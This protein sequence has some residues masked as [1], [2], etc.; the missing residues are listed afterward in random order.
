MHLS[1]FF[2]F[3]SDDGMKTLIKSSKP[4]IFMNQVVTYDPRNKKEILAVK[5]HKGADMLS[6]L[7]RKPDRRPLKT[8][9]D[10]LQSQDL[11][12]YICGIV[13]ANMFSGKR[14]Y[15]TIDLLGIGTKEGIDSATDGMMN[16]DPKIRLKYSIAMEFGGNMIGNGHCLHISS[17]T[18]RP[19]TTTSID[20]FLQER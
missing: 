12:A 14:R 11:E 16:H 5:V 1:S 2:L 15:E 17:H 13:V 4:H 3:G 6:E 20:L 7:L 18:Q 19:Y 10:Y 8:I 9:V